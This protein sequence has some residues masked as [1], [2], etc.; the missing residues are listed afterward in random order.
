MRATINGLS[1]ASGLQ[2]R[3]PEDGAQAGVEI[4]GIVIIW[5]KE[6]YG[7]VEELNKDHTPE[8]F[9]VHP[10]NIWNP[11]DKR[12]AAK[13]GLPRHT[14]LKFKPAMFKAIKKTLFDALDVQVLWDDL[15]QHTT[16]R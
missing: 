12:H 13:H 10:A 11:E 1:M 14:R 6:G 2:Q 15:T 3:T 16:T 8:Q 5:C 7:F 9:F 4:L